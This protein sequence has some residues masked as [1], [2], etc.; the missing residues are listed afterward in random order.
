M[1]CAGGVAA[2]LKLF[3]TSAADAVRVDVPLV[4]VI[5]IGKLPPGVAVVVLMV[6]VEV[7]LPP[8][9]VA[10]FK[11]AVAPAGS[12][13]DTES[14]TGDVKFVLRLIGLTL[15]VK[16]AAVLATTAVFAAGETVG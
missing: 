1:F 9:T 16:V 6:S 15:T 7:P 10:G 8:L 11:L 4:P 14:V 3:T 12:P 5:V 2:T 13:A